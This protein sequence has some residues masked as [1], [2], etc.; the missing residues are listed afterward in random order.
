MKQF[1]II[2]LIIFA[3]VILASGLSTVS[4]SK[5]GVSDIKTELAKDAKNEKSDL[6]QLS[7]PVEDSYIV[8]PL[9]IYG[10]AR[11]KWYFEGSFPVSLTDD[12]GNVLGG[13]IAIAKGD[14]TS[15]NFAPFEASLDFKKPESTDKGFL[16]LKKDN[17]SG[18]P[19]NDDS[20][21]IRIFFK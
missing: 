2:A 3:A 8:N 12:L 9:N 13:G 18:L 4:K 5:K 10:S 17:P 14:W 11:G 19:E 16:I 20:L 15:E 6:I 7:S 1:V 21:K